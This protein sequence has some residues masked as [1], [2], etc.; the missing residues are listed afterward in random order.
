MYTCVRC[1]RC[2]NGNSS[3]VQLIKM[4]KKKKKTSTGNLPHH[5]H[6][7]VV[8][9]TVHLM[10]SR[11]ILVFLRCFLFVAKRASHFSA[12]TAVH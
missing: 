4:L 3:C 8:V 2:R 7:S 12:L 10:Y 6:A 5:S 9:F 11:V 1:A